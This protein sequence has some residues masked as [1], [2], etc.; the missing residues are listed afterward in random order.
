[1]FLLDAE[2]LSALL[3]AVLAHELGHVCALAASGM[4]IRGVSLAATGPVI[5]CDL[6][7]T[8]FSAA[9]VSL[10]GPVFGALAWL[11]LRRCFPLAAEMSA[12]LTAVNLLP[13]LPLD[14]GRALAALLGSGRLAARV[15][16]AMRI[17]T[18][19]ALAAFGVRC[20]VCGFGA[21]PLL[22]AI[23]L[24]LLP[25]TCKNAPDDVQYS[26]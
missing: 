16:A 10:A 19:A 1:M 22:L 15:L 9:A 21:A 13:V 8:G 20:A 17:V 26:Y 3:A 24:I 6:P 5:R 25:E 2:A 4:R 11:A 14:G 23:W 7:Q 12:V 18:L